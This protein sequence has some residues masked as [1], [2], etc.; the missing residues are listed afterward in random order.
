VDEAY[1]RPPPAPLGSTVEILYTRTTLVAPTAAERL[2]L[3]VDLRMRRPGGEVWGALDTGLAVV[4]SKSARGLALAAR[5]LH[6]LGA[7]RQQTMSKYCPG[8]LLVH[9]PARGNA[10]LPVLRR[11]RPY[12]LDGR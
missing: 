4:E 5:E 12:P 2:T 11:C 7:R 10:L 3:D 8:V 6:A 1:G 9:R